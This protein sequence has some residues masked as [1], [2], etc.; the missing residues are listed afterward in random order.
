[1]NLNKI[2]ASADGLQVSSDPLCTAHHFANVMFNVMRGGVFTDGYN[3]QTRDFI[4]FIS[5][6]NH[7]VLT[8]NAE[9]FSRLPA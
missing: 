1:M 7:A 3:I 9:F 5:V 8:E 6:R 2:V 4:E